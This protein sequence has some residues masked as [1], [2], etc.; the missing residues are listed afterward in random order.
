MWLIAL[1][2]RVLNMS[3]T[4]SVVIVFVLRAVAAPVTEKG[5][6]DYIPLDIGYADVPEA[7]LP[8]PGLS[9]AVNR[10]LSG[11]DEAKAG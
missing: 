10:I 6:I 4:A 7:A 3:L 8:V 11:A 9:A 2:Q 1:F 5:S